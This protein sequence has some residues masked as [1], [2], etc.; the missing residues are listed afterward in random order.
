MKFGVGYAILFAALFNSCTKDVGSVNRGNYPDDIGK[1]I[2]LNCTVSG[3]HNSQSY[4]AA[5][6]YNLETWESMF[7]GSNNGSPVIPYNVQ[8][9]SLCYFINTFNDLGTQA[10]PTMPLNAKKLSRQEV[11]TIRNWIEKG[12]PDIN[13]KIK[14]ADNPKRKKMYAVNQGCDVVTVIDAETQLPMRYIQVGNKPG[15]DTPHFIRVSPDGNYWYVIFINNNIM[16]KYSCVD[17][18]YLGQIPLTPAA[19]G[20]GS[21]DALDWNTFAISKDGKRAYCVSWTTNGRVSAVDLE[22]NKLLHFEP[23]FFNS[24]GVVLNASE[25]K[26]YVTAQFGNYITE[27]DTTLQNKRELSLQN[28]MPYSQASSLNIHDIVL[29]PDGNNLAVTCQGSNEVRFFNIPGETVTDIVPVGLYPQEIIYCQSTDQYFVSCTEDSL[30]YRG[31]H[32]V[33]MRINAGS[34]YTTSVKCGFQPHGL[35]V[36]ESKKTLYVLSRN[37]S[38]SGPLPHHTSQCSGKNGFVNFIDLSSFT[39]SNKRYELSVDPYYIVARP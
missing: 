12:A 1:I 25:D 22:H 39:V 29:S 11:E 14:W 4:P 34:K 13:G 33:I 3:C 21:A 10:K 23:G 2:T 5:S 9:S 20:I 30:I 26:L 36:D 31:S 15:P 19:A 32:G 7:S 27:V 24:H 35:A 6:G 16:Q 38:S 18:T 37:I 28:G 8:F 17:D